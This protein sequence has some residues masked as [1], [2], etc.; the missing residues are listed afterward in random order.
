MNDEATY[1]LIEQYLG[2]EL[3]GSEKE[4]F[5]QRLKDDPDFALE[6]SL[7][8]QLHER[9]AGEKIHE[10]RAVLKEV[11]NEW[12]DTTRVRKL[13]PARW[14][15]VAAAVV[16]VLIASVLYFNRSRPAVPEELFAQNFEPYQMVLNQRSSRENEDLLNA[17][18]NAYERGDF[19]QAVEKFTALSS[20]DSLG[21]APE[22]YTAISWLALQQ[23]D[24]AIAPLESIAGQNQS[25]L[26]EQARWYL[27]M[28][29]LSGGNKNSARKV[30]AEIQGYKRH[31]KQEEARILLEKLAE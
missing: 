14:M 2:G 6:T 30:L 25:L 12:E 24:K 22:F 3:S 28:A 13:F 31:F 5:E 20:V 21:M 4:A 9:L 26:S 8:R 27:A 23:A 11:D 1:Q 7:H 17:A 16:L 10:L 18:I 15:Y 29:Y 19:E